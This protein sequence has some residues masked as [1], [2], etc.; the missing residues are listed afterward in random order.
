MAEA[1]LQVWESDYVSSVNEVPLVDRPT[2]ASRKV[3]S[4]FNRPT[5]RPVTGKSNTPVLVLL[6][7]HRILTSVTIKLV[8]IE[9][10]PCLWHLMFIIVRL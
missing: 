5:S 9:K 3:M 7:S 6:L 1:E 2:V 10:Q 8:D 4:S